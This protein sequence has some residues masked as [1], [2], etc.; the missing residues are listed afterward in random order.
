MLT[1][2]LILLLH[3]ACVTFVARR[4]SGMFADPMDRL[5]AGLVAAPLQVIAIGLLLGYSGLLTVGAMTGAHLALTFVAWR[6][7]PH[8][9]PP[10]LPALSPVEWGLLAVPLA[11]ALLALVTALFGGPLIHD[12]LTYRLSRIAHWLQ[13]G[14]I[15]QFPTNELRQS[16][17]PINV[18]LVMLWLTAPFDRGY[19]AAQLAQTYGGVLTLAGIAGLARGCG[20]S[21]TG[22]LAA[23]LTAFAMPCFITQW[24]GAQSDLLTAGL[25]WS[26]ISLLFRN[27]R[28][29]PHHVL[30]WCGIAAAV[31]AKGTVLYLAFGL[32][33]LTLCWW[34]SLADR[35]LP[36]RDHLAAALFSFTLLAA[37][38]YVENQLR[39]GNPFAPPSA[40]EMN[41]GGAER[42]DWLA[43]T[44]L[45]L[46][47]YAIQALEP[48]AN[49]PLLRELSRPIWK[50]ALGALPPEDPHDNNIYPRREYLAEFGPVSRPGADTIATGWL[51]PLLA[52]LGALRS[53][54]GPRTP[55]WWR[56]LGLILC[57]AV[58]ITVFSALF[59][60]WPT[61]FRYFTL[62]AP[63]LAL[64]V[65]T[66][67]DR[68]GPR[69]I[70]LL[71]LVTTFTAG[72]TWLRV[73]NAGLAQFH[74]DPAELLYLSDLENQ[75][76]IVNELIPTGGT[77]AVILPWNSPLAGFYR[78]TNNVRVVIVHEPDLLHL[79]DADYLR[80]R[81]WNALV[82]RPLPIPQP[83]AGMTYLA[84]N[85][86]V[87]GE[88][89]YLVHLPAS[90]PAQRP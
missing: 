67:F 28:S 60:W 79:P 65:A 24:S 27:P 86:R 20:L 62:A 59:L 76:A 84:V 13:E 2:T 44:G 30:G 89:Q 56:R 55:E 46:A 82:S 23:I 61:S 71:A 1:G 78:Q 47:S 34:R 70:A 54:T 25:L 36:W 10:R 51:I 87:T 83:T 12:A 88:P 8:A 39:F 77:V 5:L 72:D 73:K 11:I 15:R 43:K 14:S 35:A 33:P 16:Y 3:A 4:V 21:R 53:L 80:E 6:W 42:K 81:G 90:E 26:G 7:L 66:L 41:H 19:P 45:N 85:H 32:V 49:P 63:V 9:P 57:G 40:F 22:L 50:A 17:H 48:A 75:R 52:L 18:D 64:L 37:P 68:A 38:R 31:G 74:P 58:F 29:R 69:P